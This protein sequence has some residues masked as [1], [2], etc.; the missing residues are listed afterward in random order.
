[1][2]LPDLV[3]RRHARELLRCCDTTLRKME[4]DGLLKPIRLRPDRLH[5][6]VFYKVSQIEAL[7]NGET[8]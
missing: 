7:L 6:H 2:P 4:S 5:S 3:S 1:M 8:K